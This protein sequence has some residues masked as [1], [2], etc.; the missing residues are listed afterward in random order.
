MNSEN[1][2]NPFKAPQLEE[3]QSLFPNFSIDSF[4]AQ[5]GMGAVY[6]ATQTSLD[7]QVAIKIL[8]RELGADETFRASFA[9]EARAMAKL[10]HPNLIG[11]YD[12][13]EADGMPFIVMEYVHGKSLHDAAYGHKIDLQEA[14]KLIAKVSQ[15][16]GHAHDKGILHRDVKPA[17]ILLDTTAEPKLGDFGLATGGE[18]SDGLI[19]GTPG[20]AAPEV[21]HGQGDARADLYATAVSLYFLITGE[22]PEEPYQPPSQKCG[23]NR[24]DAFLTKALRPDPNHRYQDAAE[25][26][27]ALEKAL[28]NPSTAQ[29]QTTANRT[30][31]RSVRPLPSR[32]KS[33]APVLVGVGLTVAVVGLFGY[34][35]VGKGDKEEPEIVERSTTEPTGAAVPRDGLPTEQETPE[36]TPADSTASAQPVQE[37]EPVAEPE[38]GSIA[39]V[40]PSP[41]PTEPTT[42][43]PEKTPEETATSEPTEPEAPVA[44]VSTF[45][46]DTFLQR[47]RD[48][49]RKKGE[50]PL[51]EHRELLLDNIEQFQKEGEALIAANEDLVG[52]QEERQERILDITIKAYQ[53]A[54]RLPSD[55]VKTLPNG[56]RD[57]SKDIAESRKVAQAALQRQN[58]LEKSLAESFGPMAQTYA[59]GIQN[60]ISKLREEGNE[61]DALILEDEAR[62]AIGNPFRFLAIVEGANLPAGRELSAEEALIETMMLGEWACGNT[63]SSY[64]FLEKGKVE[65]KGFDKEGSWQVRDETIRVIWN[66]GPQHVLRFTDR[67]NMPDICEGRNLAN[68]KEI[69]AVRNLPYAEQLGADLKPVLGKWVH[70]ADDGPV[71][72][73]FSAD[74]K[75]DDGRWNARGT[76]QKN[77]EGGYRVDWRSG[78]SFNLDFVDENTLRIRGKGFRMKREK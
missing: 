39:E 64:D 59:Q 14:G 45:D 5:G 65:G 15:G 17:N 76:Y 4:L 74:G 8:P 1:P 67:G 63:G 51:A 26:A 58:D 75:V 38:S 60:Q 41:E 53:E 69:R 2:H 31:T 24:L 25:F 6:L 33:N 30:P 47:G 12:F 72:Y 20:F 71:I 70:E 48:F 32:Q 54:G 46:H 73:T 55:L 56:I 36:T 3:L 61:V 34:L 66:N 44:Q 62:L 19:Y 49:F 77:F 42:S 50:I 78:K 27:E 37:D 29:F 7:R 21:Y 57:A 68:G 40:E 16:L 18:D 10:N 9:Q 52:S 13:G 22:M 11:V 23:D 35:M 43:V 28:K